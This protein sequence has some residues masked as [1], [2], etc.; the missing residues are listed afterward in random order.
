MKKNYFYAIIQEEFSLLLAACRTENAQEI[1]DLQTTCFQRHKTLCLHLLKD[2]IT[3][4]ER[5]DLYAVSS[6]IFA[7]F[8]TLFSLSPSERKSAEQSVLLL[9]ASP[10]RFDET[11]LRRRED[12]WDLW[13]NSKRRSPNAQEC[14]Y[15]MDCLA[16]SFLIAAVKNA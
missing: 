1:H 5:E 11:Q 16:E 10:F 9:S 7:V 2:F 15:A 3:P 14:F 8:S 12:L 13:E 4:I 6:K